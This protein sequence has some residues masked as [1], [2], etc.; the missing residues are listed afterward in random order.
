MPTLRERAT[1]LEQ[2]RGELAVLM[3]Q[4]RCG[5]EYDVDAATLTEI[6]GRNDE[7]ERLTLEYEQLRDVEREVGEVERRNQAELRRL[8][9]PER[10][11]FPTRPASEAARSRKSLGQLMAECRVFREARQGFR[12][13][14]VLDVDVKTLLSTTAGWDP[15]D[16]R[17]GQ[18]VLSAQQPPRLVDLIP[19]TETEMSTVL[20]MEETTLTNA[21][22][23]AA[24]GAAFGEAALAYTER[25]SEVRKIAVWIP[26]TDEQL[27]DVSRMRDL[28]EARLRMMLFKRLD[29][30][31]LNGSGTAPNLRGIHNLAGV[32]AVARGTDPIPDALFK[33]MTSVNTATFEEADAVILNPQDWQKLRLLRTAD[34]VYIY[35]SPDESRPARVFGLPVISTNHQAA[36]V[37]VVGAFRMHSELAL[38]RGLEVQMTD[39]HAS[40][41]SEGKKAIR[42][43]LRVALIFSREAAFCRVTGL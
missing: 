4:H 42:A 19:K 34:G 22:A 11:P 20:W 32:Q 10:P 40:Y 30:Q 33:A 5:E 43:D 14:S 13:V 31:I 18:V 9:A 38:R 27:E 8:E 25:S 6:R 35:G 29:S 37:A 36:G 3:G 21:A 7:L 15:E 23:E 28:V 1:E 26:V 2:K 24:E 16:L 12:G 41:F 17:T 39:S